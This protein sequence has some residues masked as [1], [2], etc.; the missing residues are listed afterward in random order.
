MPTQN[1][2]MMVCGH[3]A[4]AMRTDVDPPVPACV[5]CMCTDQ[6]AATP[7]LTGRRA[8]CSYYGNPRTHG[9]RP[10]CTSEIPSDTRSAFFT[11]Q[12]DAE[13]DQFY[14]GCWGWD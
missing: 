13:F 4:Q 6:A 11:Y 12:P 3:T 2:P 9:H 5:I 8:R 1:M 10:P 14:C 7:D